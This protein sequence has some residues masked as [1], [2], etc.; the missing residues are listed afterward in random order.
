MFDPAS[1]TCPDQP[2]NP[3][4]QHLALVR[5]WMQMRLEGQ[6]RREGVHLQ[7]RT[8]APTGAHWL[9]RRATA[10]DDTVLLA[11]FA[12]SPDNPGCHSA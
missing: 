3:S 2:W 5:K 9:D 4:S 8:G 1:S 10:D 12:Q 11:A 6:V 7:L